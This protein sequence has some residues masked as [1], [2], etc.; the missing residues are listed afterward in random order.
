MTRAQQFAERYVDKMHFDPGYVE[1]FIAGV[2]WQ[3][4]AALKSVERRKTVRRKP[5]VQQRKGKIT[6]ADYDD[7]H[8]EGGLQ[9]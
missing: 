9:M 8:P 6:S 2:E 7:Y 4:T 3:K 5:P 1:G